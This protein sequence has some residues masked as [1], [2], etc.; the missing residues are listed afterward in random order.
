MIRKQKEIFCVK[1]ASSKS[2]TIDLYKYFGR[3]CFLTIKEPSCLRFPLIR[4]C[5]SFTSARKILL[6]TV[7]TKT[8]IFCCDRSEYWFHHA[9]KSI[10]A[11]STEKYSF[12]SLYRLVSLDFPVMS[13]LWS[14]H[15]T[16]YDHWMHRN[17]SLSPVYRIKM[18][19]IK[20]K[21]LDCYKTC[22]DLTRHTYKI[23]YFI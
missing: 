14:N 18:I 19:K 2:N 5:M 23:K 17:T 9:M 11:W 20:N 10:I 4:R 1:W 21:I 3:S 13:L 6:P 7:V 8:T 22:K 12:V 15:S 16:E